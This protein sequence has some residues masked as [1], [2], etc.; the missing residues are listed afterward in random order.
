M[1]RILIFTDGGGFKKEDSESYTATSAFRMFKYEDNEFIFVCKT[2][3]D[4]IVYPV[5]INKIQ[6]RCNL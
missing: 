5:N 6:S 2:V 1:K 4:I 3:C